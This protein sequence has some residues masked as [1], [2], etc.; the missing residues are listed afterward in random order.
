MGASN[1]RA[2]TGAGK[3]QHGIRLFFCPNGTSAPTN[4][5]DVSGATSSPG[6]ASVTR[7]DTGTFLVTLEDRHE[8]FAPTGI[9]LHLNSGPAV[10]SIAVASGRTQGY[11]AANS[12][13]ITQYISGSAADGTYN[14]N[15]FICGLIV[16]EEV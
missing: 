11:A 5:G 4:V 9:C 12:F 15:S 2:F 13:T 10:N 6:I 3:D 1:R 14:A 7:T 16:T 8:S